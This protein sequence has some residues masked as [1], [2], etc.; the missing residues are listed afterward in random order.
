MLKCDTCMKIFSPIFLIKVV[1]GRS[2]LSVGVPVPG[3]ATNVKFLLAL[4][5]EIYVNS[6]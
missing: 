2:D 1:P 6:A 5:V 3:E 4:G